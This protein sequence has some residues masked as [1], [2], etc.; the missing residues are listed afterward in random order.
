MHRQQIAGFATGEATARRM[1]ERLATIMGRRKSGEEFPAEAAISRLEVDGHTI[2]TV[3]LRDVTDRK[4]VEKEQR[5]L[6][7]AG[8][9]LSSSLDY[10]QTLSTLGE[11]VVRD[12]ADWC[13]VDLVEGDG[14]PTRLKVVSADQRQAPLAAQLER[15]PLDQG[16]P[17]FVVK[18][19]EEKR[20]FLIERTP[21]GQLESLAKNAEHLQLLR[22]IDPRSVLGVPLLLRGQL[23]GMLGRRT[24]VWPR[25]SRS[26]RRSRSRTDACTRRRCARPGSGTRCSA[27]SP[28]T[29]GTRSRP[30]RCRPR[31]SR[32]GGRSPSA[33]PP[34]RGRSSCA[35]PPG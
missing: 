10:E 35:P 20:P 23:L 15:V 18:A 14:R 28:T 11:L 17:P 7:E 5:F 4:R 31:R 12:F 29:S 30:S 6:A 1:G 2:L 8:A 25:R 3:A 24:F 19:L 21:A 34:S 9:V 27:S 33:V 32:A 13:I 16:R 26:A 22:S